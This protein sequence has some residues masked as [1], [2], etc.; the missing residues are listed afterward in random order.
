MASRRFGL[1]FE[2]LLATGLH[3]SEFSV[4]GKEIIDLRVIHI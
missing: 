2:A 1:P 3:R 4:P